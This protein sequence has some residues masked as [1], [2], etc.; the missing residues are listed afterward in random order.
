MRF[1]QAGEQQLIALEPDHDVIRNLVQQAGYECT[2]Q[3][4]QRQLVLE[5]TPA[6]PQEALLLFD[7]S[8]A[9]NLG[10]FSRCNFYADAV[11]GAVLQTPFSLANCL[12][13]DGRPL[14][15]LRISLSKEL[16]AT[17]R[18]PGR[19][20]VNEQVVYALLYNLLAALKETG[21]AICGKGGVEPLAGR[22]EIISRH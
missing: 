5:I 1:L 20:S 7:A 19:Q 17:F 15:K 10:W 16:P 8:D 6:S 12:D 11:S 4:D 2:L 21:V 9:A 14:P 3:E 13:S 18:L 22:G